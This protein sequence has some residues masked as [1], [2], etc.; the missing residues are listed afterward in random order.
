V[1]WAAVKHALRYLLGTASKAMICRR[2]GLPAPNQLIG[3]EFTRGD[4][5][6]VQQTRE[7]LGYVDA[8][9]TSDPD[10]RRSIS[11]YVFMLNGGAVS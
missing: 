2:D 3:I 1:H 6:R 4:R 9:W 11:G 5:L 7:M 10:L 8:D